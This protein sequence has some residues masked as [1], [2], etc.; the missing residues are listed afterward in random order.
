MELL[1]LKS[2]P[3]YDL[4]KRSFSAFWKLELNTVAVNLIV[5]VIN[6]MRAQEANTFKDLSAPLNE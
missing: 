3:V 1:N 4:N 5:N 6:D 2:T